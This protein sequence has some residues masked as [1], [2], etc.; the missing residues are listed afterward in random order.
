M[1]CSFLLCSTSS[2]GTTKAGGGKCGGRHDVSDRESLTSMRSATLL[3]VCARP[4]CGRFVARPKRA[5]KRVLAYKCS[6]LFC[7][8]QMVFLCRPHSKKPIEILTTVRKQWLP[9][10]PFLGAPDMFFLPHAMWM[11]ERYV[12]CRGAERNAE[13]EFK[14]K[15]E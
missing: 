3:S 8:R 5:G 6:S 9:C 11:L 12:G 14:Q 7:G 13:H 1:S 15:K 10:G 4:S 2:T